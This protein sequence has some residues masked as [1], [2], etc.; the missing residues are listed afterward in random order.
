MNFTFLVSSISTP[1]RGDEGPSATQPSSRYP[2]R[3][4]KLRVLCPHRHT[5]FGN[6]ASM[7]SASLKQLLLAGI[8]LF[9]GAAACANARGEARGK[10]LGKFRR[11]GKILQSLQ[12][13]SVSHSKSAAFQQRTSDKHCTP[14][15]PMWTL[16]NLEVNLQRTLKSVS[17]EGKRRRISATGTILLQHGGQRNDVQ[18]YEVS[19]GVRAVSHDRFRRSS[20]IGDATR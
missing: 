4:S 11:S 14:I 10:R 16:H 5:S 19:D 2:S 17:S 15:P 3:S 12:H 8:A 6:A 20:R 18:S 1:A 7:R 9:A 13:G